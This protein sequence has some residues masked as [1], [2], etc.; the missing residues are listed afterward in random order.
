MPHLITHVETTAAP[1]AD[2]EV[3]EKIHQAL[4]Q[5]NLSPSIHLVDA[6]YVD[7]PLL[8]ASERAHGIG[9][10]P[11]RG[12]YHWQAHEKQ[13]FAASNFT[14]DWQNQQA[15]CPKERKSVSWSPAKIVVIATLSKSNSPRQIAVLV[16]VKNNA[17]MHVAHDAHSRFD[18]KKNI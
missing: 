17:L 8:A 2:G 16:Q 18:R 14:I 12:D 10:G 3:T 5:K 1:V 13:G 6:G 9:L 4:A 15:I 11:T 7:G